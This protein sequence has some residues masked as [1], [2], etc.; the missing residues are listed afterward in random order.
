M[1]YLRKFM[2]AVFTTWEIILISLVKVYQFTISPLIGPKCRFYP[3]CSEY[4]I[5]AIHEHGA[6]KGIGLA[7]KRL[8]RCHPLCDGGF[9]PVPPNKKKRDHYK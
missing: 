1:E 7:F 2:E 4:C 3:S 5:E 9:D 8:I 6:I